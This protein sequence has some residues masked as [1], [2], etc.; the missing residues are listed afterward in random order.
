MKTIT[1]HAKE[2]FFRLVDELEENNT[3]RKEQGAW[4]CRAEKIEIW[5]H[6]TK[7]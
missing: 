3:I 5:L 6:I 2:D 4:V 1:V 7:K